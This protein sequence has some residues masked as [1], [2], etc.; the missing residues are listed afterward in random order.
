MMGG[1]LLGALAVVVVVCVFFFVVLPFIKKL[2]ELIGNLLA[3]VVVIAVLAGVIW[4]CVMFP[5]LIIPLIIL[6]VY[7][8]VQ[9]E[10]GEAG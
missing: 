6:V 7:S 3:F 4:L 8:M 5:V 10:E 1:L 9:E 2:I